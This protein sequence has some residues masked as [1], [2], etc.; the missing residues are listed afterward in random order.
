MRIKER[1]GP[2]EYRYLRFAWKKS[3]GSNVML[4]LHANG[5][6]GPL[7]GAE[8][9]SYR[10]LAGQPRTDV[11]AV[12]ISED[13]PSEWVVVTRDLFAD[14]GEFELDGIALTPGDGEAAWFDHIYLAREKSDLDHLPATTSVND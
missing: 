10:Y 8:G 1:P 14:F 6:W 5:N 7:L 3:G 13:L 2:G 11:K 9:P 12:Q 4:Q